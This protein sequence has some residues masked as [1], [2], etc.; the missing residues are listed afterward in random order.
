MLFVVGIL[1]F[2][3]ASVFIMKKR[4]VISPFSKGAF[5]ALFVSLLATICLG[6]NYTESLIPEIHDGIGISNQLA[7]WIIGERTWSVE[8]FKQYFDN[9]IYLNLFLIFIYPLVLILEPKNK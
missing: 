8:L 3:S 5:L 2:I 4:N 6:Q 1:A 7:Y 9:S